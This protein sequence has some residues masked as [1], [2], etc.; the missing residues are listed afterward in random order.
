VL[1]AVTIIGIPFAIAN[2]KLVACALSPFGREIVSA[3][4]VGAAYA[5][6]V[7]YDRR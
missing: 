7:N 4:A 2:L 6:S 1:L 5:S 3:D